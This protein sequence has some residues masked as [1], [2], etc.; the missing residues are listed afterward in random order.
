LSRDRTDQL[1]YRSVNI[2][3]NTLKSKL[4]I[5]QICFA[6]KPVKSL[7]KLNVSVHK[8]EV[9]SLATLEILPQFYEHLLVFAVVYLAALIN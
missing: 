3:K 7:L 8:V 9:K 2:S 5:F 1:N 6:A 4:S